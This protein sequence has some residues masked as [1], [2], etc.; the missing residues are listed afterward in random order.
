L[1]KSPGSSDNQHVPGLTDHIP[2]AWLFTRGESSVHM[3]VIERLRGLRVVVS[4]PGSAFSTHDFP[5]PDALLAFTQEKERELV[6]SGFQLHAVAERR[7]G[8]GT[9]PAGADRRR[10]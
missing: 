2:T 10:R 8:G 3:E 1:K 9:R 4:G 5:D 7:S 6:A